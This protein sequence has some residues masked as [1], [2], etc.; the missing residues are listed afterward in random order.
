MYLGDPRPRLLIVTDCGM[1]W[2]PHMNKSFLEP[3]R[4]RGNVLLL[5]PVLLFLGLTWL[6]ATIAYD[7]ATDRWFQS[8]YIEPEPHPLDA[9]LVFARFAWIASAVGVVAL[10]YLPPPRPWRYMQL[11]L[12][13]ALLGIWFAVIVLA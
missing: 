13:F 1:L 5:A 10:W 7:V 2:R 3:Y 4:E 11:L 12:P 6:V 9:Y 8:S